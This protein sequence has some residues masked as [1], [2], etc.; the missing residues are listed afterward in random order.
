MPRGG[1]RP[2]AGRK[3]GS[4]TKRTAKTNKIAAKAAGEGPLPLE[5]MLVAMR[6]HYAKKRYDKAAAV[7]KDAAP[8][9]HPRLS[10]MQVTGQNGGPIQTQE[11]SNDK[12]NAAIERELA[13]LAA[14]RPAGLP[15]SSEAPQQ[16]AQ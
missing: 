5:V 2:G 6:E 15:G 10:A 1:K 13:R 11:L 8:Y 3:K 7:A 16:P 9:V 4:G 14:L 12:V